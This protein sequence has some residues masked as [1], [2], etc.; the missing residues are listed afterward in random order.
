MTSIHCITE[1]NHYHLPLDV[2]NDQQ[3]MVQAIQSQPS[4]KVS[5]G[6]VEVREYARC[7]GNHPTTFHDGPSLSI[8]WDYK[9]KLVID[10]DEYEQSK[11]NSDNTNPNREIDII[12]GKIRLRILRDHTDCT[13]ED[14]FLNIL[15]CKHT[16]H[17]RQMCVENQD[18]ECFHILLESAQRKFRRFRQR[19][20]E[21]RRPQQTN[22]R[23]T[24]KRKQ[25]VLPLVGDNQG[26]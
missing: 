17:K 5:F 13:D 24:F 12:P 26:K 20:S 11:H 6:K 18:M 8:D 3:P 4:S 9:V 10:V 19:G 21:R 25:Q 15:E 1:S 22:Q 2:D 23:R 7:L 16:D 14:I